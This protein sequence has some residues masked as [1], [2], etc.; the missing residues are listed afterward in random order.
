MLFLK[1]PL[2]LR[3]PMNPH[4]N[5]SP[6]FEKR[7][8]EIIQ[9][10]IDQGQPNDIR[11]T[12]H[13]LTA[14]IQSGQHP[15]EVDR[16]MNIVLDA[17]GTHA[18]PH[19]RAH[20]NFKWDLDDTFLKDYN[21]GPFIAME[22]AFIAHHDQD[23]LAPQTRQRFQNALPLILKGMQNRQAD[24]AYTN[25]TI[26]TAAAW[27]GLSHYF[28][29]PEEI[30]RA[31][32]NFYHWLSFTRAY[33]ITE[34]N[35]PNY[36]VVNLWGL[37]V[38]RTFAQDAQLIEDI[39]DTLIWF[40]QDYYLHYHPGSDNVAG[41]NSRSYT[42]H[43]GMSIG[44]VVTLY[45]GEGLWTRPGMMRFAGFPE[46]PVR[47][48]FDH[49][50]PLLNPP[51]TP[52]M[53]E[54]LNGD[55]DT[56]TYLAPEYS[57]GTQC[58]IFTHTQKNSV[59]ATYST[60][61]SRRTFFTHLSDR[62]LSHNIHSYQRQNRAI[63]LAG[64]E[65]INRDPGATDLH[66]YTNI[67]NREAITDIYL[68]GQTW[69]RHPMALQEGDIVTVHIHNTLI[70]LRLLKTRPFIIQKTNSPLS[71]K[72]PSLLS[73]NAE[74]DLELRT[75]LHLS[76]HPMRLSQEGLTTGFI[77]E[78]TDTHQSSL[79]QLHKT[80]QS[81]QTSDQTYHDPHGLLRRRVNLYDASNEWLFDIPIWDPNQRLFLR[82][83]Q[84]HIE[85]TFNGKPYVPTHL[86]KSEHHNI[87]RSPHNPS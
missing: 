84:Q 45:Y 50:R 35:S 71:P 72:A 60:P 68:N 86:L 31:T 7:R 52:Y 83:P 14:L 49:T 13:Y 46:A 65:F 82:N 24:V 10:T 79:Q 17:Q 3:N 77:L 76:D 27:L 70:G 69:D 4:I 40:L 6:D 19:M 38:L 61:H 74:G 87:Y 12:V 85:R 67:A 33:G 54:T 66:L 1:E 80:L 44:S 43:T 55:V 25:I 23:R 36:A 47:A 53:V 37:V 51:S 75:Y 5:N 9:R 78:L 2:S 41:A 64:L 28:N 20:G 62:S 34:F 39:E 11:S 59:F 56:T 18:D 63:V 30:S 73:I 57:L 8:Q 16:V 29:D 81:L 42:Y 21:A 58:G 32:Q 48:V 15:E 22:L 26:I